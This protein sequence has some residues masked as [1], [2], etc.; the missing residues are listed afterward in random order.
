MINKLFKREIKMSEATNE[1][2]TAQD[3]LQDCFMQKCQNEYDRFKEDEDAVLDKYS[4]LAIKA[5]PIVSIGVSSSIVLLNSPMSFN[6][7]ANIIALSVLVLF[8]T[9]MLVTRYYL[10]NKD[11]K[12][13]KLDIYDSW[14]KSILAAVIINMGL[15]F[16]GLGTYLLVILAL[17]TIAM[18]VIQNGKRS[19]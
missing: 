12:E 19:L 2:V 3:Y 17:A 13:I 10:K 8:I 9:V 11:N 15:Y 18:L 1:K 7:A 5:L 16:A 4:K 14:S 6:T